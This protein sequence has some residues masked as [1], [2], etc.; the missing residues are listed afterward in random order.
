MWMKLMLPL[1]LLGLAPPVPA[2]RAPDYAEGQVWAYRTRPQ[3]QGSVLRIQK[4]ETLGQG[5]S[6]YHI[7]VIGVHFKGT[8]LSGELEHLPVSRQTL[9]DSVTQLS[10]SPAAFPD[11][12]PGIAQWRAAKGGVFTIPLARIVDVVERTVSAP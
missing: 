7:S 2:P 12:A 1:A 11:A 8:S 3:D 5:T 6:V 9:D 10:P 4:I